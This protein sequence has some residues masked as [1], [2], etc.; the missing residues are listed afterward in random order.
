[1]SFGKTLGLTLLG[2]LGWQHRRRT[3][4]RLQA[5]GPGAFRRLAVVELVVMG[6]TVALAVALSASPPPAGAAPPAGAGSAA[7]APAPPGTPGTAAGPTPAAAP[8]TAADPMAGHDH[9]KLSVGVLI[10]ATR[11]HVAGPVEAGS[12]VSVFNGTDQDV[13]ITADDGS[14]DVPVTG[15][16][17]LTFLAPEEPGQYRFSSRHSAAFTDVLVVE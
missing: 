9:G 1:M 11:F 4:P 3:M 8:S 17:L 14:F 10:D 16:T 6:A 2:G 12:R 13:T 15:H 7:P 5:G